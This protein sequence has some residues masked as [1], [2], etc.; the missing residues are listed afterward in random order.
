MELGPI[1]DGLAVF[2]TVAATVMTISRACELSLAKTLLYIVLLLMGAMVL[3]L[4]LILI[5]VA[6]S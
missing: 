1:L 2:A 5:S 4:L 3:N 6:F